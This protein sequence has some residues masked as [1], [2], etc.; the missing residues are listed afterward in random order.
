MNDHTG[1]IEVGRKLFET[2]KVNYINQNTSFT[3]NLM[4]VPKGLSMGSLSLFLI[5]CQ[6]GAYD[7]V[8]NFSVLSIP[9]RAHNVSCPFDNSPTE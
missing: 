4:P 8:I 3:F 7:S 5:Y 1:S 2:I 6:H 9:V